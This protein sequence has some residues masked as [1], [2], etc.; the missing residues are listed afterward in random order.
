MRPWTPILAAVALVALGAA[1]SDNTGKLSPTV[2]GGGSGGGSGATAGSDAG[3]A[4]AD[5]PADADAGSAD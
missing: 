1:C 2:G 4:T 5:A 3:D